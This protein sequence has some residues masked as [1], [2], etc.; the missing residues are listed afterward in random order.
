MVRNG[1]VKRSK[2]S[3]ISAIKGHHVN[4]VR[5]LE[6]LHGPR[7]PGVWN[8]EVMYAL[9]ELR[10]NFSVAAN[11]DGT[12]VNI[13]L[14]A[15]VES[16]DFSI[17]ALACDN[18]YLLFRHLS[19]KNSKPVM[20]QLNW[21]SDPEKK[22]KALTFDSTGNSLLV[23]TADA[24]VYVLSVLPHLDPSATSLYS[25][26]SDDLIEIKLSG[27][28]ASLTCVRWW[29]TLQGQQIAIIGSELGEISFINLLNKKEV[30]GTY[31]SVGIVSLDIL[32]DE[33]HDTTYLLI[34]GNNRQQWRLL[35]EEKKTDFYWPSNA[36]IEVIP[37]NG[38]D[39]VASDDKAREHRHY[40]LSKFESGTFL[41]PQSGGGRNLVS[42]YNSSSSL[43]QVLEGDLDQMHLFSY[44]VPPN[45]EN[46]ILTDKLIFLT[47]NY[48]ATPEKEGVILRV[49]SRKFAEVTSENSKKKENQDAEIQNFVVE[50]KILSIYKQHSNKNSLY[51]SICSSLPCNEQQSS[52]KDSEKVVQKETD[53]SSSLSGISVES[54]SSKENR[55]ETKNV[56]SNISSRDDLDGCLI[57]QKDCVWECHLRTTP[58]ELF[59]SYTATPSDLPHAEKLG[60]MLGLDIHKLYEVAAEEQLSSGHFAQAVHL[61]Q[62]SKCPQL[63]RIA[64]FMSYGYLSELIAYIQVLFSTKSVEIA[65]EDKCHF[66]N[67]ALHCFA[68]QVLE[69]M[70]ERNAITLAFKKFL[71]DNVYYD[72][73]VAARL[74]A[75]QGLY[76]LLYYFAEVRAQ[77]GLI[78]N[79]LLS[80]D[81]IKESLD[82]A[83]CEALT[84]AGLEGILCPTDDEDYMRCMTSFHLLQFLAGNPKLLSCHLQH[85]IT[86]LPKMNVSLLS[87]V[88]SLYD[89]S[90]ATAKLAFRNIAALKQRNRY[91]SIGSLNSVGSDILD[92]IHNED[93]SA[94]EEDVIKFFIFVLLMLCH[95]MNQRK[96]SL[97]LLSA[98]V[99]NI[100]ESVQVHKN[101]ESTKENEVASTSPAQLACGL[102]HVAYIRDGIVYTWG[103]A[104]NG[105]L[106]NGQTTAEYQVPD[107]VSSLLR[108]QVKVLAVSC[109]ALHTLA[110][111]D[112]GVFGWGSSQYGQLG[113]E[114]V[115]RATQ[116][117]IIESLIHEPIVA[118]KCGQYHSLALTKDGR[119]YSWGWGVHGQLGHG[120]PEN[121][122]IPKVIKKLK[123]KFIV[124]VD[125][126]QCHTVL[127]SRNGEVYTFGC[128]MFGQLGTGSIS[129]SSIPQ[130]VVLPEPIKLIAS[131]F[132]HTVVVSKT[133]KVYTWG[134]NP[135]ALRLQAQSSR[136]ARQQSSSHSL[137][138]SYLSSN[139]KVM[140]PRSTNAFSSLQ[141]THLLPNLVDCSAI[142]APISRVSCGSHHSAVIT[143]DGEV[144]C[145]GRNTEGQ[146]GNGTRKEQKTPSLVLQLNDRKFSDIACGADF[147]I[148]LDTTGRIWGWG[149]NDGGQIGKK[150][151][152]ETHSKASSSSSS[153]RVITIR[154]NRRMITITQPCRQSILRPVE[155][156][157]PTDEI[158]IGE[159]DSSSFDNEYSI[160]KLLYHRVP[161]YQDVQVLPN[162][163]VLDDPPYGQ[164]ALH[165]TLKIFHHCYDS[166][167]ILNHCLSFS[168]FQAAAK[169]C[170]LQYLY[171]QAVEYQLKALAMDH[172][173]QFDF[174]STALKI[175]DFYARMI[176][177]ENTDANIR[178]IENILKFWMKNK[179]Q[180]EPLELFFQ[181]HL[182]VLSYPLS[183]ILFSNAL[184]KDTEPDVFQQFFNL[185]STTFCLNIT[186]SVINQI[187]NGR[188]H[189]EL[190]EQMMS[191]TGTSTL[192]RQIHAADALT[193]WDDSILPE[194]LWQE[195]LHNM[196]K[197]VIS[198]SAI[199]LTGGDVDILAKSLTTERLCSQSC[200]PS[201]EKESKRLV[202]GKDIIVFTCGHHYT[203]HTFQTSVLPG[204][205]DSMQKLPYPLPQT[206]KLLLSSYQLDGVIP[207]ACP[208]CVLT[209][210]KSEL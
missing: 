112:C 154:T 148:T 96:F 133:N 126:G 28:R 4:S 79:T 76:D 209:D 201:S 83:T 14:S 152:P 130:L 62:L 127:L 172:S 2:I 35:L 85:L 65:P 24:T 150:P 74:L 69:K 23:V 108:L 90:R 1:K 121:L 39:V 175:I 160:P 38:N 101:A 185:L 159:L 61:Y 137:D 197:E 168:D 22:I 189:S 98:E 114:E 161:S 184:T 131:G 5:S 46:I 49:L 141:Q 119:A 107:K 99:P 182:D 67:I 47:Q 95:K 169:V 59:L 43:L 84:A 72:E 11:K 57:I 54:G 181:S 86:L 162:L 93:E 174:L 210:I 136:R 123:D 70:Q 32:N 97:D 115:Q 45:C 139:S 146:V 208:R 177:S 66:A 3:K 144:Y 145:W 92:F 68:Q 200:L 116:P 163:F 164:Y 71:R 203:M 9:F 40:R 132:F 18:G 178:F 30:G 58:A 13:Q 6:A 15:Y 173:S 7:S 176:D 117:I 199:H 42:A 170:T 77:H 124:S 33:S 36:E 51:E 196:Q 109:G 82:S 12:A 53:T 157:I 188:H 91:W 128:G 143:V 187:Q 105:R 204:F 147:T 34:T 171:A 142:S 165:A 102:A 31:V 140:S 56:Q 155:I 206:T 191:I 198:H 80:V 207:A 78:V 179:L 202:G 27:Q 88:A 55:K 81:G 25:W 195:L 156:V 118:V 186:A 120:N 180:V 135:Q 63:K 158:A 94:N 153:G 29:Q 113:A 190:M 50:N 151:A 134:S 111:T 122:N 183:F 192:F 20:R 10:K 125:A 138:S 194:R 89:P 205:R 60:V 52:I 44:R 8:S 110:L 104:G 75:E 48:Q 19:T 21:F 129:K 167:A 41:T 64:H 103:K 193:A 87:R 73:E 100:W 26:R 166:A 149:Q 106:G 37:C 17:L 16:V